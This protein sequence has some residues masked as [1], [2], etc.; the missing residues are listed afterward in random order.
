MMMRIDD[1]QSRSIGECFSNFNRTPR[2]P[3]TIAQDS[4]IGIALILTLLIALRKL[5]RADPNKY[6]TTLLEDEGPGQMVARRFLV[7]G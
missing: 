1:K 5:A 3:A 2:G 6:H 4:E 7:E